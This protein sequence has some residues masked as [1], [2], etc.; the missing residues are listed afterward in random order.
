M[1]GSV[2][3]VCN[4]PMRGKCVI[5][6]RLQTWPTLPGLP[7][8]SDRGLT[9]RPSIET[10]MKIMRKFRRRIWADD[11]HNIKRSL[12]LRK[13][14]GTP[15]GNPRPGVHFFT[16]FHVHF[17]DQNPTSSIGRHV[18]AVCQLEW[19][20]SRDFLGFLTCTRL[21]ASSATNG[22]GANGLWRTHSAATEFASAVAWTHRTRAED[23]E[24]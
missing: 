20:T 7:V 18:L 23:V 22:F 16:T 15:S 24:F 14:Q 2:G 12:G 21:V 11:H 1:F 8:I 5:Q 10:R 9:Q 3:Y 6:G 19:A 17:F 13:R 4:L